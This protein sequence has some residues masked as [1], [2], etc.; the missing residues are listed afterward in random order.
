MIFKMEE[1]RFNR[2]LGEIIVLKCNRFLTRD[3]RDIITYEMEKALKRDNPIIV[4]DKDLEIETICTPY[5]MGM[6]Y[7]RRFGDS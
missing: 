6:D 3:M 7:S 5:T 4:L 1:I 2:G